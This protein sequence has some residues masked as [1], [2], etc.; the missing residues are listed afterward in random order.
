MLTSSWLDWSPRVFRFA[1]EGD[2]HAL[3]D[4]L[5]GG[6]EVRIPGMLRAE[7]GAAVFD[8]VALQG[9]FAVDEGGDDV[10]VARFAAFED[11]G[12]TIADV[13]VDHRVAADFQGEGIPL[14]SNPKGSDIDGK[15]TFLF[16]LLIL[17]ETGGN[18]PVN[19]DV[20]DFGA[21]KI[22]GENDCAGFAGQA[23]DHAFFL[24]G[25]EM[26]HRR[27]LAGEAKVMLDLARL[28]H[29]AGFALRFAEVVEDLDLTCC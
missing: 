20:A 22:L 23:L 27:R 14:A 29:D 26:A 2:H 3:D 6:N 25:P 13:G 4:K 17:P 11:D 19:R 12:I 16:L 10:M 9:G 5:A 1:E 15:A 18:A 21:I 7:E 28:R 8:E 24:K